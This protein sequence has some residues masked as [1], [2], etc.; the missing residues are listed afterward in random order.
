MRKLLET[1]F[2]AGLAA[3]ALSVFPLGIA[4]QVIGSPAPEIAKNK[5]KDKEKVRPEPVVYPEGDTYERSIAVDPNVNFTLC[6]VQGNLEIN[7]WKR[8]EIRV[9][10]RDGGRFNFKVREKSAKDGKPVWV[11]PIGYDNTRINKAFPDCIWGDEIEI[12]VPAGAA[13]DIRGQETRTTID[14]V[15]KVSVNSVGGNINLRNIADGIIASTF[16]GNI[17]LENSKGGIMLE[18]TTGNIVVVEIGPSS[19]GDIFKAKTNG[20]TISLQNVEHR[21]VSVSSI[22]GSIGYTGAILNGGAYNISTS[23]GAIR[24]ALPYSTSCQLGVIYGYGS[25]A[26]EL[27]FKM[28]METVVGGV[29]KASGV[30]GKGGDAVLKLNTNTGSIGIRKQEPATQPRPAPTPPKKPLGK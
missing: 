6:V 17:T 14:T 1:F 15:K 19:I 7:G 13:I 10:I 27:P 2:L 16:G 25:F 24:L 28:E 9:F 20:G 11:S 23:N 12:D 3:A 29:K 8:N 22:S 26:S 21:Q 30:F 4:A 18:T 5:E